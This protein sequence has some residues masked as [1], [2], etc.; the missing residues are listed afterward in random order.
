MLL[1]DPMSYSY[2]HYHGY[3]AWQQFIKIVFVNNRTFHNKRMRFILIVHFNNK[4]IKNSAHKHKIRGK[5][6]HVKKSWMININ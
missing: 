6:K 5:Q 4:T 3:C 2:L 1:F